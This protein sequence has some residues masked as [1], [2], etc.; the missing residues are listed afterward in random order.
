MVEYSNWPVLRKSDEVTQIAVSHD[1][2][3]TVAGSKN[4]RFTY[5]I[6]WYFR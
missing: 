5:I 4:M 1:L 2:V 6:L 3:M